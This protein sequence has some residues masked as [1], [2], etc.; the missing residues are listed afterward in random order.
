[1]DYSWVLQMLKWQSVL[2]LLSFPVYAGAY[3]EAQ[4]DSYEVI[5]ESP[6][7]TE[8]EKSVW[9]LRYEKCVLKDRLLELLAEVARHK[10][11]D[12]KAAEIG[13]LIEAI[14]AKT[15]SACRLSRALES[16]DR[17][18]YYDYAED[19]DFEQMLRT[20]GQ[21]SVGKVRRYYRDIYRYTT[22]YTLYSEQDRLCPGN[23]V[24]LKGFHDAPPVII[25]EVE[26][27][28]PPE[29]EDTAGYRLPIGQSESVSQ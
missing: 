22:I 26:P 2:F 5:F 13:K 11:H 9:R 12:A 7:F 14:S 16:R 1:M 18:L 21:W 27:I 4:R 8:A 10:S 24:E 6:S 3:L 17:G 25:D 20:I 29:W 15:E 23:L 28:P 19:W